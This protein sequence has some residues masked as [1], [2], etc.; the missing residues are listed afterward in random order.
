MTLGVDREINAG[1]EEAAGEGST[2]SAYR[3]APLLRVVAGQTRIV[4]GQARVHAGPGEALAIDLVVQALWECKDGIWLEEP[5][6]GTQALSLD[7]LRD[8][9]PVD[10][11]ARPA[12]GVRGDDSAERATVVAKGITEGSRNAVAH[13]RTVRY[14]LEE[15]LSRTLRGKSDGDEKAVLASL[16]EV[17]RAGSRA[18]DQ[19]REC[20]REELW[21]WVKVGGRRRSRRTRTGLLARMRPERR[22]PDEW[23]VT[24]GFALNH[25]RAM[26]RQLGEEAALIY[27]LLDG[28]STIVASRDAEAQENFNTIAAIAAAGLGL[29]ALVL[30][31]YG[32]DA[33]LPFRAVGD[34]R[35]LLPVAAALTFAAIAGFVVH[36]GRSTRA[37][38]AGMLLVAVVL[39]LLVSA[40][41]VAPD[42]EPR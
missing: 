35:L 21:S 34:L 2:R 41:F 1:G 25:C 6:T 31:L 11:L 5:L 38:L 27:G 28:A 4:V 32:A 39:L 40:A 19:A 3:V 18:R 10:L 7:Q 17:G 8:R 14:A 15:R 9:L 37:A 23:R 30:A 22:D 24:H 16:I 33:Y 42:I 20:E 36:R 29:P 13:L 26:E 12:H